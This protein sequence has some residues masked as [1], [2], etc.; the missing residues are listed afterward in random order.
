MSTYIKLSTLEYPRH[1][2]DIEID[3][4][5]MADYAPV[6]W[7]DPPSFNVETE[8]LRE[9]APV[10]QNGQ[11]SMNWVVSQIPAEEMSAMVRAQRDEKLVETDWTQLADS[12]ADKTV[13]ATYRQALRDV[14]SQ[15]GFP[16]NVQW[17][18]QPE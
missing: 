1:I 9:G 10:Q 12:P 2:G 15:A 18:A 11:W 16:W 17:P 7:I 8:R 13:W 4:A 6:E 3:P 5:G 14:P